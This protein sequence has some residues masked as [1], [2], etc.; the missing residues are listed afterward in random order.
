MELVRCF[1]E[2]WQDGVGI[3]FAHPRGPTEAQAFSQACDDT[4]D[5]FDRGTLAMQE[6]AEGLHEIALASGAVELTPGTTIGM[7]VGAEIAPAHPATLGT[8]RVG[9]AIA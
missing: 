5:A 2:P 7:T 1:N 9:A 3:N 4:Y 8:V 6:R